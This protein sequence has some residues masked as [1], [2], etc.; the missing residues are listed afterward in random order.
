MYNINRQPIHNIKSIIYIA[1]KKGVEQDQY[2]NEYEIYDKPIKYRFNVQAISEDSEI[3]EFGELS[4]DMKV[5]SI[6]EKSKY[7][8][9]F[10]DFDK[11]YVD[12]LPKNESKYGNNADYRIYSV[13]NQNTSIRIYLLKLVRAKEV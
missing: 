7:I 5:I 12:T 8:N 6:T 4:N 1:S 3:R 2:L 10:K 13:R 9:K 11:V